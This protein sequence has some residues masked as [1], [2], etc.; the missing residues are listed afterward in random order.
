MEK[1][2]EQKIEKASSVFDTWMTGAMQPWM[3]P[4]MQS[5]MEPWMD[6]WAHGPWA[7]GPWAHNPWTQAFGVNL[8]G[9][10][11]E[12]QQSAPQ[13]IFD[14]W[15]KMTPTSLG[16]NPWAAFFELAYPSAPHAPT[17]EAA[18]ERA[19]LNNIGVSRPSSQAGNGKPQLR[20]VSTTEEATTSTQKREAETLR[21]AGGKVAKSA[22]KPASKTTAKA[23]PKTS[24]AKTAATKS[25]P[26]KKSAANATPD[27]LTAIK[28]VGPKLAAQLADLGVKR[29]DQI[30]AMSTK[31]FEGLDEKLGAFRGRWRRD[32][33]VGQAKKLTKG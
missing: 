10:T 18:R 5:W 3:Q 17:P 25:A 27:D 6:M 20:V 24:A 22:A 9:A 23:A 29:F 32:D 15:M 8:C 31:D 19:R 7:H 33:W 13:N 1:T 16:S 12:S 21:S 2:T 11:G 4:W 14:F 30:A 26:A 28:G